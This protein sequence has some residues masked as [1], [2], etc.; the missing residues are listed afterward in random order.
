MKTTIL[1]ST[2]TKLA[3]VILLLSIFG[4]EGFSQRTMAF[5]LEGKHFSNLINTNVEP[6]VNLDKSFSS[7][8]MF[9][10]D[11]VSENEIAVENWML[12]SKIWQI[13]YNT[14]T[15]AT[16]F[17]AIEEEVQ[18]ENW[19]VNSF[20]DKVEESSKNDL[21]EAWMLRGKTWTTK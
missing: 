7:S 21:L 12:D 3:L 15:G 14:N 17:A 6:P 5:Y 18:L 13:D 4:T 16:T 19:M 11:A 10:V 1:K 2:S 8:N 9:E 20:T